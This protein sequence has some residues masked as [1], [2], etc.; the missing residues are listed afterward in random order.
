MGYESRIY[1]VME[2]PKYAYD[3][4]PYG[5]VIAMFDLRK[6]GYWQ[7]HGRY[8]PHLFDTPR[9]CEFYAD[10]GN[11]IISED[12]Y[13]DVV[14]KAGDNRAVIN[15]LKAYVKDNDWCRAKV[16]L[17]TL[18]SLEKNHVDYSIYHYGY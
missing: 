11:T 7:L 2:Y 8:F 6:M 16:F 12:C 14:Y 4:M 3:E 10:D 9:T 17:D 15:W 5:S 1:I 13:G 18:L